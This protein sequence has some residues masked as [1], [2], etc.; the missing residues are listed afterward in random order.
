MKRKITVI[1]GHPDGSPKRFCRALVS[2]YTD[3]ASSKGHEVTILRVSDARFTLLSSEAEYNSEIESDDIRDAQEAI[4]WADHLVIF[5]PLWLGTMPA[6][7]KGYL[8]QIFRP[9][10]GFDNSEGAQWPKQALKGR[11]ARVVV[12]MGMPEAAYRWYY[13]AH[14]LKS[15][16][17]NILKFCGISPVRDTVLGMVDTVSSETRLEWLDDMQSL[18][19]RAR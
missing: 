11:T 16:E 3:G 9:G 1:D 5:Y 10:F 12:T 15:L 8:E 14:S 18:G 2:A 7:L 17:R 6:L 19:E 4:R 13:F